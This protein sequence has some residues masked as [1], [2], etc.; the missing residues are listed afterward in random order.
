VVLVSYSIRPVPLF[1][2]ESAELAPIQIDGRGTQQRLPFLE[3]ANIEYVEY[4][5]DF[6]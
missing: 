3:Y 1:D 4:S 6:T 2:D 5:T